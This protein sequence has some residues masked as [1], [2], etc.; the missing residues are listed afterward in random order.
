VAKL[1]FYNGLTLDHVRSVYVSL[2]INE[3]ERNFSYS[4]SM[5]ELTFLQPCISYQLT[6]SHASWK[7]L[8]WIVSVELV[9]S[10]TGLWQ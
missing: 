1:V 2:V 5:T 6:F 3:E 4:T 9:K 7:E 10:M 8:A